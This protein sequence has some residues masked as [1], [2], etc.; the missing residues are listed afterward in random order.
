MR[1]QRQLREPPSGEHHAGDAV[2]HQRLRF[3][4]GCVL[5]CVA[6]GCSGNSVTTTAAPTPVKCT[7][8]LSGLP[9]SVPA[10]GTKLQA[11]VSAA[12]ECSWSATSEAAWLALS[13]DAG[14]G[15]AQ[16]TVAVAANDTAVARSGAIA[17]NGARVTVNQEAA[18]CRFDLDRSSAQI[19]A[20]GGRVQIAIRTRAGCA[21]K[22]SSPVPWVSSATA[23]GSGSRTVDLIVEANPGSARS[24]TVEVAGRRFRVDQSGTSTSGAPPAP[25]PSPTPTPT[26]TPTPDPSPTPGP[27]PAPT[28]GP[29]PGPAPDPPPSP[30]PS[31]TYSVSDDRQQFSRDA[32]TGR[33]E[34]ETQRECSW[35]ASTTD[36]WIRVTESKGTGSGNVRFSV[37]KN[38]GPVRA[39]TIRVG[40][41][42]VRVEQEGRPAERVTLNGT[43]SNL[44]GSCPS[45]TF[46]VDG[47]KVFTDADTNFKGKEGCAAV[48]NGTRAKVE[49][50]ETADGRVYA[51]KVEER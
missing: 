19:A 11:T 1:R 40:G 7:T 39:G 21:W 34:V 6:A 38:N 49:G 24:A 43:V 50:E 3:V 20:D 9:A 14:Q 29:A 16:V 30:A 36:S 41:V 25:P 48:A 32:D 28:P 47:Q 18:A 27:S 23:A 42:T 22:V 31:C 15:E 45:V 46:T 13:P 2:V 10:T 33:F 4:L 8:S 35:T 51:T 12:R 17:V 37:E 5:A 44:K 26:P